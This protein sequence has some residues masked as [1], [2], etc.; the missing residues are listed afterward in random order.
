M[1]VTKNCSGAEAPTNCSS[2]RWILTPGDCENV[3]KTGTNQYFWH[4]PTHEGDP[5]PNRPWDGQ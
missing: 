5:D 2:L 3:K 1:G 4:Y